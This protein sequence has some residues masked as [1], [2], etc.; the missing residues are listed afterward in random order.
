MQTFTVKTK[1][2]QEIVDITNEVQKVAA[3]SKLKEG[4]CSIYV[5][6]ATCSI[7]I[8]E[9]YDPAVCEDILAALNKLIPEHAGYKHDAIDNN[10]AA[11]LKST[12]LGPCQLVPV[13]E[14]KIL[15]GKWQGIA[16]AEFDGPRERRVIV[17]IS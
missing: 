17:S 15:L 7:I 5:P 3:A 1:K 10:A 11:H 4:I 9:N 2:K 16:L 13:K 6:H 12:L 8:N 14:G